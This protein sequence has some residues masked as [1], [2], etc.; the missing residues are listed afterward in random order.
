MLKRWWFN[1]L[2]L[3]NSGVLMHTLEGTPEHQRY[4]D[5]FMDAFDRA[6][7][8]TRVVAAGQIWWWRAKGRP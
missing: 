5:E 3:R 1:V 4:V 2:A 7:P 6:D 8:L